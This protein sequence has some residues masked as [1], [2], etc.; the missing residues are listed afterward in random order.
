[1]EVSL[2]IKEYHKGGKLEADEEVVGEWVW[3]ITLRGESGFVEALLYF[4]LGPNAEASI[5][6]ELDAL[7]WGSE[8]HAMVVMRSPVQLRV[9]PS[10]GRAVGLALID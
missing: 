8:W 1:L 4:G 7:G 9:Q 2:P 6:T 5:G 3:R 10:G